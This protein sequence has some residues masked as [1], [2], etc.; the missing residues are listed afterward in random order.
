MK[1]IY[2]LIFFLAFL[3][4]CEQIKFTPIEKA[5]EEVSSS[6]VYSDNLNKVVE[7]AKKLTKEDR[8]F[9]FKQFSGLN[10]YVLNSSIPSSDKIDVI[11]T[12]VQ[13]DYKWGSGKY[14]TFTDAVSVY[15]KEKN[16]QKPV[17]FD[18]QANR[19]TTASI[20]FDL[21]DAV[22]KADK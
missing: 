13:S 15:L 21:A 9:A 19:E 14:P 10:Q 20:F 12:R 6:V 7:E 5:K 17:K 18:T 1:T 4:G 16:Y 8:D 11:I 2:S 3:S 22:K